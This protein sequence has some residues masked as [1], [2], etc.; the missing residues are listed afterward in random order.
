M[1]CC[2][3]TLSVRIKKALT[4]S[5]NQARPQSRE[6]P[7]ALA[8]ATFSLDVGFDVPPGFTILF[9]ASGSGKTTTLRSISG[10][11]RPDTGRI[12]IGDEVLFDS[13]ERIDLP[14]RKR[15]VGYVFQDLALFPHLTALAN[16]E[17]G[18]SRMSPGDRRLRA[19]T[20]MEALRISHVAGR[21]PREISGGDAQ[22]VAL[23]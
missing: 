14:I 7:G 11:V 13:D 20:L 22:R 17:F 16:V 10:I 6:S 9:G 2:V 4:S 3:M 15:G 12:A 8:A 19:K 23:A 18:M 1:L 21:K 5:W